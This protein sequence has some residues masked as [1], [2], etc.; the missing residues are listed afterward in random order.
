ML[1]RVSN[2][3][4]SHSSSRKGKKKVTTGNLPSSRRLCARAVAKESD[5]THSPP[6]IIIGGGIIGCSIAYFLK[7]RHNIS[8]VIVEQTEIAASSSGKAGGFLARGWGDGGVTQQLHRIS[9]DLHKQLAGELD[10]QSYRNIPVLSVEPESGRRVARPGGVMPNWL[11]GDCAARML[12]ADGGA[13]VEPRELTTKLFQASQADL[14]LGSAVGLDL[15]PDTGFCK[16]VRVETKKRVVD[17]ESS[18]TQATEVVVLQGR[19]VVISMGVWSVLLEDWLGESTG[20]KVP[21]EG[22]KSTSVVFQECQDTAADPYALFCGEDSNGCHLEVYP[23]KDGSVYV[24]GIGGSDYVRGNRLR[25]GGDC[26]HAGLIKEDPARVA[27]ACASLRGMSSAFGKSPAVT[28]ACMRPCAPDALPLLGRV[29]ETQNVLLACGHNCWG[30]LW[31]PVT[32]LAMAEM[33]AH[34]QSKTVNLAA[35]SPT[36]FMARKSQRGRA[37]KNTTT[38]EQW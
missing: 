18:S 2:S 3:H 22:V 33:I 20:I 14:F 25:R 29:P 28:Q 8:S 10:I 9:Y 23:R 13:Q 11:D 7:S 35:F 15:D 26:E 5:D 17:G 30:I 16:G 37:M 34:G 21:M 38:G 31:A 32:G 6:V 27:A 4:H 1:G 19:A 12:D 24:C 36:R